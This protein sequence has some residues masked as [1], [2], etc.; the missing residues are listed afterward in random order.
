MT[1][2]IRRYAAASLRIQGEARTFRGL[3]GRAE[4]T[5]KATSGRITCLGAGCSEG[6]AE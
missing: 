2:P 3:A 6:R 4:M 1:N 5:A